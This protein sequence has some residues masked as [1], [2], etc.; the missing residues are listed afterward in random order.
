VACTSVFTDSLLDVS[1]LTKMIEASH[2]DFVSMLLKTQK[3]THSTLT[4]RL[5]RI[6]S[7]ASCRAGK[8]PPS[9]RQTVLCT[10][11]QKL[12]LSIVSADWW[13]SSNAVHVSDALVH[14]MQS[15]SV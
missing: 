12:F 15:N 2:A 4:C 9:S 3:T 11:P 5:G 13:T 6:L 7:A 1:K 14:Q 10:N 8:Q